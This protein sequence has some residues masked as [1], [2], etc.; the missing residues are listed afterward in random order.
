[1]SAIAMLRH[2]RQTP[3]AAAQ[4]TSGLPTILPVLAAS[5]YMEVFVAFS[6]PKPTVLLQKG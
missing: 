6:P 4:I 2:L 3:A 5:T 1:M